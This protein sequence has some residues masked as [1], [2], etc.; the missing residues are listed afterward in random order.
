MEEKR[1]QAEKLAVIA[2]VAGAVILIIG[3]VLFV[4]H[5]KFSLQHIIK[6]D[7]VGQLGDFIGGIV[8]SFWALAG[9]LLFY[10][11]LKSQQKQLKTQ[12][13]ELHEQKKELALSREEFQTTRISNIIFKQIERIDNTIKELKFEKIRQGMAGQF[14]I[15]H[16]SE[17]LLQK[18][19][20][21]NNQEDETQKQMT[22]IN[23]NDFV[24]ENEKN[25]IKVYSIIYDSTVVIAKIVESGKLA[26][27]TKR[28]LKEVFSNNIASETYDLLSNACAALD[29]C[30]NASFFKPNKIIRLKSIRDRICLNEIENWRDI[31]RV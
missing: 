10:A 15:Y 20:Y 1:T 6:S 28:Q 5:E 9:V 7:K 12:I 22:L 2:A 4:W 25:I 27:K 30:I 16:L 21:F 18:R 11:A 14:G 8:G 17:S 29:I 31:E 26:E 13:E 23:L 24:V 19:I 3:I